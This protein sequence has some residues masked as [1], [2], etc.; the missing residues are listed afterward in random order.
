M[1]KP[2]KVFCFF[3]QSG[4]FKNEFIK[5][6]INAEDYDIRNDFGQ[7][8]H[9]T[10][11]FSEINKAYEGV[12]SVFDGITKN[13]LVFA[14]FPCTRFEDQSVM[15][16]NGTQYQMKKYTDLRKL[17]TAMK[18]HRELHEMYMSFCTMCYVCIDRGI[19]LII[20]NPASV[21]HYLNRYF[22]IKPKLVDRDRRNDGD[23]YKKPTQYWF[24]NC[25]VKNKVLWEPLEIVETKKIVNVNCKNRAQ[26][27]SLIHPQYAR[28]FILSHIV[29]EELVD[30][31]RS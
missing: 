1:K 30:Y 19:P 28:R 18:T 24:I 31:D 20:E 4:T 8:D 29:S 22:P 2:G 23:Y 10:D 27:R 26:I 3:E 25:E 16:L 12:P 6:G 5:M 21:Q 14:F 9:V 13:D 11:L 17:E 7:T 15:L